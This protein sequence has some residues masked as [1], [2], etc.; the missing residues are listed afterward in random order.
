MT[1]L[2]VCFYTYQLSNVFQ[3]EWVLFWKPEEDECSASV[4]MLFT[5]TFLML[6]SRW[7]QVN[8]ADEVDVTDRLGEGQMTEGQWAEQNWDSL[9]K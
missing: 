9:N 7:V 1:S 5:D 2:P 4:H 8:G 3:Y 6:M